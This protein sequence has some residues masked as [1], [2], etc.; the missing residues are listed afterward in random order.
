[1]A[2]VLNLLNGILLSIICLSTDSARAASCYRPD[3]NLLGN[4]YQPCNQIRGFDSTCCGTNKTDFPE[5]CL[6]NGLCERN[7]GA[8]YY[9]E[10][11]SRQNFTGVCL[12]ICSGPVSSLK[13]ERPWC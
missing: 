5:F 7:D 4:E 3:G 6:A 9:R 2:A 11:C 8:V 12:D 13:P 1:M 10:G